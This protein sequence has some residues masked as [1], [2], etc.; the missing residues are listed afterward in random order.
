MPKLFFSYSHRDEDLRD[1]LQ[2]HLTSLQRQGI[3]DTWHDRRIEAGDDFVKSISENLDSADIILLLVSPY[4][5][6]SNY[7]YEVEMQHALAKHEKNQ[8]IVIPVILHPCDW[9]NLPFGHLL[10]TPKDGKPISKFPNIHD[11]FLDVTLAVKNVI[12]KINASGDINSTISPSCKI[13]TTPK[14]IG[15]IRSSNLRVKKSFTDRDKDKF[16]TEAFEYIAKY[17]EGSLSELEKRNSEIETNFRRI[18]ANKF[19][20]VIYVNGS[21]VSR[22]TIKLGFNR[23][24]MSG[25]TYSSSEQ[26]NSYNECMSVE[27]DGQMM[28]L[29]T[30]G[31]SFMHREKKDQLSLEG[32][33]EYYWSMLIGVI[34]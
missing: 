9:H 4:F 29:K 32:A 14:I 16:K 17:F 18:D 7:C 30:L 13:Q 19:S 23:G 22:C 26:D 20:S 2:I 33:A 28:F 21:E 31:M 6:S 1:E 34:Q 15:D 8:S 12:S 11:G 5:I 24:F 27:D 25:I 3:L 10:A